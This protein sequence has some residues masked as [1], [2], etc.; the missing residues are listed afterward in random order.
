MHNRH[1]TTRATR[2]EYDTIKANCAAFIKLR[3]EALGLSSSALVERSTQARFRQETDHYISLQDIAQYRA[4]R[5]VPKDA[6]L[7]ALAHVLQCHVDELIPPKYQSGR[8]YV[9]RKIKGID[10]GR[11]Q[12][13]SCAVE[14]DK[15]LPGHAWVRANIRLPVAK[16][17]AT[18]KAL[19]RLH[20]IE[21]MRRMGMSDEQIKATLD[22]PK[23][24]P[25]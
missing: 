20:N 23:E 10:R 8:T 9:L 6:K 24:G 2:A 18:A 4:A 19:D 25:A 3:M 11:E 7:K 1:F 17:Y 21:D 16:A 5:Q 22:Q 15:N 12:G 14:L 13:M